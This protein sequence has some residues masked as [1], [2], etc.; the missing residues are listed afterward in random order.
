M[1]YLTLTL[2]RSDGVAVLTL[3]RPTA[4]N[5]INA[6][7]AREFMLAAIECDDEPDTRAPAC[8]RADTRVWRGEEPAECIIRERPRDAD[9]TRG[10][11]YCGYVGDR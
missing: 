2:T 4:G 3:N 5:T 9:A 8:R 7:L 11:R 6:V 1:T 10:A